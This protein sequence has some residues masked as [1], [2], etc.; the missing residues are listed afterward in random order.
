MILENA[1]PIVEL[2]FFHKDIFKWG[3]GKYVAKENHRN[4]V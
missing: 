2:I 1:Y 4:E 3:S